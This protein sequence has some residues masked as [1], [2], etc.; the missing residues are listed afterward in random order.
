[1][2]PLVDLKEAG[3]LLGLSVWTVRAYVKAGKLIPIRFG[4]RVLL[5]TAELERFVRGSKCC[6]EKEKL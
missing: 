6:A 3:R 5:E 4:R 1:M 2:T